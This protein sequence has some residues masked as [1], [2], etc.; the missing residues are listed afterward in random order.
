MQ[1]TPRCAMQYIAYQDSRLLQKKKH[2]KWNKE[3]NESR[4]ALKKENFKRIVLAK[5]GRGYE[6]KASISH[7]AQPPMSL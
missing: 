2:D 3:L 5:K 7:D 1:I 4:I 6:V